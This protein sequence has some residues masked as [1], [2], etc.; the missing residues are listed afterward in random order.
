MNH[1]II[2]G[3]TKNKVKTSLFSKGSVSPVKSK[4]LKMSSI[5]ECHNRLKLVERI[6]LDR[7]ILL[8][9]KMDVLWTKPT[10]SLPEINIVRYKIEVIF[11]YNM[12]NFIFT[13]KE[14]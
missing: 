1:N 3:T 10:E 13:A 8:K 6:E 2:I 12:S 11:I 4:K 5:A 7:S 9:G 14:I